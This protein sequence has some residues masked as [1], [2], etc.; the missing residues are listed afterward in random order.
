MRSKWPLRTRSSQAIVGSQASYIFWSW[1]PNFWSGE[2]SWPPLSSSGLRRSSRFRRRASLVPWLDVADHGV[3]TRYGFDLGVGNGGS[4]SRLAEATKGE[5]LIAEGFAER[6]WDFCKG[7][8]VTHGYRVVVARFSG[9]S[10]SGAR[11]D[12]GLHGSGSGGGVL[13]Q[14]YRLRLLQ[15]FFA[16]ASDLDR[17][18]HGV[19]RTNLLSCR[20]YYEV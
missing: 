19:F 11:L 4:P 1:A 10:L 20:L 3:A 18:R 13:R 16:P 12:G 17:L 8:L 14:G 5:A 2:L 15:Y 7:V 9:D 6:H